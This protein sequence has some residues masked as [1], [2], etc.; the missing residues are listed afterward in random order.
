MTIYNGL[1]DVAENFDVFVFDAYGV[2]W[3]GNGF[4][5]GSKEFMQKLVAEGKTV[6]VVSNSPVMHEDM[7]SGYI[8]RNF[9]LGR[10]CSLMIS[11]GEVVRR[12]V[13]AQNLKFKNCDKPNRFYTIGLFHDKLWAGSAYQPV[14]KP[15]D[16]DFVFCGTPVMTPKTVAEFPQY[17]DQYYAVRQNDVGEIV[18]WDTKVVEPFLPIIDRVAALNLPALNPNPDFTAKEGHPLMGPDYSDFMIRNGSL[19]RELVKR[20]CELLEYGKPHANIYDYTFAKLAQ[21]GIKLD[22][23][24]T[25]MVGDTVRTDIKGAI[26]VGITPILCMETGVTA[27]EI[28][29]G[30]VLENLCIEDKIDVQQIVQIKSVS[31]L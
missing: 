15:E 13:L 30:N 23:K 16:A 1:A 31:G 9:L 24:R 5:A 11:S 27:K 2:F 21:N 29:R 17:M 6:V 4:Y 20:G 25:C 26:N 14:D 8:K 7:V 3:E 22:K 10:D 12:D 19:A 18:I 28:S